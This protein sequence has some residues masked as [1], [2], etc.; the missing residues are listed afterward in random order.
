MAV[1]KKTV[2]PTPEASAIEQNEAAKAALILADEKTNRLSL[3]VDEAYLGMDGITDSWDQGDETA[4]AEDFS[5]A[6]I[7]FKRAT[8]LHEAAIRSAQ[9]IEKSIVNVSTDL[10]EI[11]K[12]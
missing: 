2:T 5:L 12:P 4:S 1:T 6:A 9:A 11:V 3:A 7:G 10:A 8:A